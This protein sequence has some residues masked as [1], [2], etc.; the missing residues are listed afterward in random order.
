MSIYIIRLV[1]FDNIY[2]FYNDAEYLINF[3]NAN[4]IIKLLKKRIESGQKTPQNY[5]FLANAYY[6][7]AQYSNA[8][9]CALKSKYLDENYYYA[10]FVLTMIYIDEEN[11]SKAEKYLSILFEKCPQDYYFA[12]YAAVGLYSMKD[13]YDIAQKYSDKLKQINKQEPFCETLKALACFL[14]QD[15][16]NILKY[17]ISALKM[18]PKTFENLILLI[19]LI[20]FSEI[21]IFFKNIDG[22][23]LFRYFATLFLPKDERYAWLS[24]MCMYYDS[25]KALKN[26]NKAIKINPKPAYLIRKA[27]ILGSCYRYKKAINIL[28]SVIKDNSE[29]TSVYEYLTNL[30]ICLRDYKKALEYANLDLLNNMHNPKMYHRKLDILFKMERYDDVLKVLDKLEKEFPGDCGL[31]YKRAQVFMVNKDYEKALLYINKLL[32]RENDNLYLQDKMYCLFMLERY[33]EAIDTGLK[34]LGTEEKGITCFWLSRCYLAVESYSKALIYINKAILLGD[35]DKWDYYWKSVILG[36]LG[37]KDE[38][39]LTFKKSVNLG[40]SEDD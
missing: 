9:K 1:M 29:Y 34:I 24:D 19:G 28:E 27:M 16:K 40:Y 21:S 13:E 39:E 4:R 23:K 7:K 25:K 17:S 31:E 10:D 15:Y 35:C 32:L 20:F 26:I 33:D 11:I 8:L 5:A 18:K 2:T 14:E 37:R 22:I 6:H 30:Y 12:Y 38:A 36:K 3:F